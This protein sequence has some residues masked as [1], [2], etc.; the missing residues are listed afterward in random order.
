M[1]LTVAVAAPVTMF[2]EPGPIDDV[3]A[4]VWSRFLCFAYAVGDVDLA[5]LVLGAVVRHVALVAEL[6]ERLAETR[7]VAVPEDPP[8]AGDEA[9]LRPVALDVLLR[10]EADDGLPDRQPNRAHSVAPHLAVR[11]VRV[12]TIGRPPGLDAAAIAPLA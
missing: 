11:P 7:D 2:V 6:L 12:V 8:H 1:R 4:N 3:Q 5:L 9:L 10:Q